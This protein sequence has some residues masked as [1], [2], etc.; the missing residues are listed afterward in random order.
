L[1]GLRAGL[2][3][4]PR[5]RAEA[6]TELGI[7]RRGAARI[8]RTGLRALHVACGGG[9]AGGGNGGSTGAVPARLVRLANGAPALQPA[10]DLPVASA[11]DLHKPRG[12]Q[13]VKGETASSAPPSRGGG[14][15][16]SAAATSSPLGQ[17][18]ARSGL[19]IVIAVCL[20]LLAA[21]ALVAL[22]RR[23]VAH[24]R[25]S[26]TSAAVFSPAA[27]ASRFSGGGTAT[28]P[29]ES[30]RAA[31]AVPA[32][33][34]ATAFAPATPSL[35]G[36][37]AASGPATPSAAGPAA[38]TAAKTAP[39][40]AAAD[41]SARSADGPETGRAGSRVTRS[42]GVIASGVVSLA[43]RELMRRRRGR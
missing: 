6:A 22:R 24:Q 33:P 36:P 16:V 38:V 31:P 43:V 27:S 1:L 35:G 28:A 29:D 23:A 18:G 8:E 14:A 11:P 32:A 5:T 19:P 2:N 10:S 40:A 12:S 42:A 25:V 34:G 17:D 4:V 41:D 9:P 7:S 26:T 30:A 20:A 3:G 15:P 13:E 37:A 21:M 39:D